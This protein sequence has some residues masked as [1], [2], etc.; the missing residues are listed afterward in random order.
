MNVEEIRAADNGHGE[1]E[2]L[3]VLVR[4]GGG[5][6]AGLHY[7]TDPDWPLQLALQRRLQGEAIGPFKY[8]PV[9]RRQEVSP[10]ATV[11]VVRT[12][13]ILVEF[14]DSY[15][16]SATIRLLGPGDVLMTVR[17]GY[18]F[19]MSEESEFVE[20]KHGPYAGPLKEKTSFSPWDGGPLGG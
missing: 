1:T 11:I 20:V 15:N 7:V 8:N 9:T 10:T 5:Y 6:E 2:L 14:Y 16:Q 13:Q 4:R 18:R 12:G 3:A 17:G 19:E